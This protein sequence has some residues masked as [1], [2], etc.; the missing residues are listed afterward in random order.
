MKE[1][2][3]EAE[4]VEVE[5]EAAEQVKG[6]REAAENSEEAGGMAG[7]PLS[8]GRAWGRGTAQGRST[9]HSPCRRPDRTASGSQGCGWRSSVCT[10]RWPA[11][12]PRP[13]LASLK[14]ARE[15]E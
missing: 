11:A 7:R 13:L 6:G 10:R 8:P 3:G 5:W 4:Q 12:P 2:S 15:E 14:A 1:G 9:A